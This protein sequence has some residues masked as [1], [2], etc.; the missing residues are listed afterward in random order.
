MLQSDPL[1]LLVCWWSSTV[2]YL[3]HDLEGMLDEGRHMVALDPSHFLGHLVIGLADAELD[4]LDEAVANLET[5]RELSGGA[6][7]SIG[8]LALAFG[9]AG[10]R[11]DALRLLVQA[12]AESA[13]TYI[14]PSTLALGHVGLEDWDAAFRWWGLAVEARDPVVVPIKTFPFFDP[15]R[16]RARHRARRAPA[17]RRLPRGAGPR[18][19]GARSPGRPPMAFRA[20]H[21]ASPRA[22]SVRPGARRRRVRRLGRGVRGSRAP[23]CP[24]AQRPPGCSPCGR[25]PAGHRR[26]TSEKRFPQTFFRP[27][28]TVYCAVKGGPPVES[29]PQP[30]R[31]PARAAVKPAAGGPRHPPRRRALHQPGR[32]RRHR[33]PRLAALVTGRQTRKQKLP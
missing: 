12:E 7:I 17:G 27:T 33:R 1:S 26:S 19:R 18:S 3:G 13:G 25:A 2:A 28:A 5:A 6:P 11:D 21:R 14:P 20:A 4:A 30:P 24:A 9:R 16:P 8:Y 31:D 10:R 22:V 15:V 29:R 23:S 32:L